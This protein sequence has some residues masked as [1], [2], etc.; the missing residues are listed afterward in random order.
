MLNLALVFGWGSSMVEQWDDNPKVGGSSPSLSTIEGEV[1][2]LITWKEF[3][4]A[5]IANGVTD[6]TRISYIDFD[7][8]IIGTE[9]VVRYHDKE[10]GKPFEVAIHD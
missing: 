1:M 7:G 2:P 6:D 10:A 3:V 8:Y 5:A 9:L 4:D